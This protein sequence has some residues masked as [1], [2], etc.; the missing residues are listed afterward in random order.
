MQPVWISYPP[1]EKHSSDSTTEIFIT[2]SISHALFAPYLS[3]G[4]TEE[5]IQR[6]R[7]DETWRKRREED[8]IVHVKL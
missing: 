2:V 3:D 1:I 8:T 7:E 6:L 5:E 4:E